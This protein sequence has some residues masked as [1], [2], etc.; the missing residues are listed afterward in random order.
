MH[1]LTLITIIIFNIS[2]VKMDFSK[3]QINLAANSEKRSNQQ[4]GLT[5]SQG[6]SSTGSTTALSSSGHVFGTSIINSWK[7]ANTDMTA[8]RHRYNSF[9]R[10]PK[11]IEQRPE[12]LARSGFYYSGCGDLF[13]LWTNIERMGIWRWC[14][15]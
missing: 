6:F 8:Y 13:L 14:K 10:W 5:P 1:Y 2:N 15:L 11:Q 3:K 7:P 12:I 4:V 9:S